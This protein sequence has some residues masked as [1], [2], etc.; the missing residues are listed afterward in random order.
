MKLKLLQAKLL[1]KKYPYKVKPTEDETTADCNNDTNDKSDEIGLLKECGPSYQQ[2]C[3]PVYKGDKEQ[4]TLNQ[5][6][7]FV[8]PCH[9]DYLQNLL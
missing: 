7:L 8:K 9:N 6:A 1:E 2:F 3:N 4:E 5:T